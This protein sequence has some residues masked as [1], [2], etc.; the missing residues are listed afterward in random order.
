MHLPAVL[1]QWRSMDRRFLVALAS[2]AL[3]LICAPAHAEPAP[4]DLA[5]PT[6]E[7]TVTRSG[8]TLPA[9]RVPSLAAGDRLWL[10]A[11]LSP[12]Q[13]VH[14]LMVVAFPA[15]RHQ[16]APAGLVRAL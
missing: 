15:R 12:Q 13:D 3:A 16:P 5:G 8:V 6:L 4:F 10:R 1:L 14:Y 11:D 7:L 2:S 9:A